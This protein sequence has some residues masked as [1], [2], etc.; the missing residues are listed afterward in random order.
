MDVTPAQLAQVL[1]I[2]TIDEDRARFLLD[3]AREACEEIV[4]PLPDKAR[5]IVLDVAAAAYV[6]TPGPG[7]QQTAGPFTAPMAP[8]GVTLSPRQERRLRRLRR[9]QS[10]AFSVDTTPRGPRAGLTD[11]HAVDPDDAVEPH[12]LA[13]DSDLDEV[14]R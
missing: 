2:S 6:S 11:F 10:G 8:G 14:A 5:G 1:D 7:G 12:S 13:D 9:R 3:L 4:T